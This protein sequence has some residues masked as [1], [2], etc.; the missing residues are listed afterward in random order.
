[1]PSIDRGFVSNGLSTSSLTPKG[2]YV[3]ADDPISKAKVGMYDIENAQYPL[4]NENDHFVRFYINLDDESR[5]IRENKVQ[6]V[7]DVDRTDQNRASRGNVSPTRV[8]AV[9]G[10]LGAVAGGVAGSQLANAG[11]NPDALINKLKGWRG[12][13]GAGKAV[14]G[15]AGKTPFRQAV[16][17]AVGAAAGATVGIAAAN[18][19]NV[20]KTLKRLGATITLYTPPSIK[21]D[22]AMNWS[23]TD[24]DI[25]DLLATDRGQE[26]FD[27]LTSANVKDGMA[28]KV[29]KI[30][31]T[32]AST[33][34]QLITR[35]TK[36]PK[37]DF[38]FRD[39]QQRT[40]QFA[41]TFAPRSPKEALEVAKIIYMFKMFAHPDLL[42]GY[43]N[44]LYIYPAEWDI[45][46][47]FKNPQADENTHVPDDQNKF[48]NRISSCVLTNI[49]I[50]YSP[51]G[52]FQTLRNG[53]P[54]VTTMALVFRELESLHQGRIEVGF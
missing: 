31:A 29:T 49:H 1:M 5:L 15:A 54:T 6:V 38:L 14:A 4:N 50:E 11:K 36:N 30:L 32:N 43:D 3:R 9:A 41:Y 18:T 45:V 39:V 34:I 33:D 28:A 26:M 44:F 21:V 37:K 16:T 48:L 22:Y 52:S 51:G 2:D 19:L 23:E 17:K 47:G 35:T 24:S 20:T 10:A 12:G 40:F 53:E 42:E 8:A 27:S 13:W 25:A 46:Y 7:G